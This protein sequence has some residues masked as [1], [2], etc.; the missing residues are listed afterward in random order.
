LVSGGLS[1]LARLPCPLYVCNGATVYKN[2]VFTYHTCLVYKMMHAGSSLE[3]E[4]HVR[5]SEKRV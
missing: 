4:K 3:D 2:H 1:S 5:T